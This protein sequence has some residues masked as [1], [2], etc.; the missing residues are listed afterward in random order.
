MIFR[1]K[2][3]H[4]QREFFFDELFNMMFIIQKQEGRGGSR[5]LFSPS[6]SSSLGTKNSLL[7]T[8]NA[9]SRLVRLLFPKRLSN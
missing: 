7:A 5:K 4:N 9:W 2:N 3:S 1:I 6:G 8:V